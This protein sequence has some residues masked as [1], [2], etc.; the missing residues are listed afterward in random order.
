MNLEYNDS[1]H[2]NV[3]YSYG[4]HPWDINKVA[5]NEVITRLEYLCKSKQ[6]IAVGEI[7][8]D[9]AIDTEPELQKHYFIKQANIADKYNMPI[10]VHA[11]KA[12]SDLLQIKK[13][14][15][16]NNKWILH[17][18]NGSIQDAMQLINKQCFISFGE[19][20]A[21]SKKLQILLRNIPIE[22]V[23]F[24]TDNS[25]ITINQVYD[26]ASQILGIGIDDLREQIFFNFK[27]VFKIDE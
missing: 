19:R 9:R 10:I 5:E 23:F 27:K 18:F 26:T 12:N 17:A 3:A 15:K 14:S 8:I 4:L 25:N 13:Q 7:G 20:L 11:V 1:L 6:I 16:K 24:E 22:K 2:D 21:G